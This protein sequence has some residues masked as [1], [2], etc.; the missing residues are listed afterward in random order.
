MF[1]NNKVK[2]LIELIKWLFKR[3][4][5]NTTTEIFVTAYKEF[6]TGAALKVQTP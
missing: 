4:I 1:F 2:Q 5:P 6:K 3:K